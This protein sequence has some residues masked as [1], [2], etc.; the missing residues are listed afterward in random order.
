MVMEA[1]DD[2]SFNEVVNGADLVTPD[3][4]PLVWALKAMGVGDA[5]RVYGPDLMR[6]VCNMAAGAS[7][8][9]GLYGST[10][11]TLEALRRSLAVDF[12]NITVAYA[13]SPPFGAQGDDD[14]EIGKM[15]DAGVGILFVA[16][17]C[18]KQERWMAR[19]RGKLPGVMI[20]VGA[21]FDFLAR[22][23]LEAPDFIQ[24]AGLEWA[25]RLATEPRRLWRRYAR[26]NP[27]FVALMV[28]QLARG[29]SA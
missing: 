21:A 17:G 22:T 15:K 10:P 7:M 26:H 23:K 9:V 28:K 13:F 8:R 12:P 18:P 6:A 19:Q 14:V 27:R 5:T 3:G 11:E 2:P 24:K 16:L 25:F 20:G 4:V 29:R 1:H